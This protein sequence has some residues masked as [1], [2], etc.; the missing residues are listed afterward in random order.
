MAVILCVQRYSSFFPRFPSVS[1]ALFVSLIIY[2]HCFRRPRFWR[3]YRNRAQHYMDWTVSF[4]RHKGSA[5]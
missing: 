1:A 3:N 4:S 2:L 5:Y